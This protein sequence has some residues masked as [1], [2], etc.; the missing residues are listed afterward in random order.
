MGNSQ[1][2]SAA[3]T[4]DLARAIRQYLGRSGPLGGLAG[5][6][7][8]IDVTWRR[9][10]RS[11][12][13]GVPFSP[14]LDYQFALGDIGRFREAE[15]VPAT[16]AG[17]SRTL[18]VTHTVTLPL[19]ISIMDRYSR[20]SSTSWS[21]VLDTQASVEA[22]QTT[23]PDLSLRWNSSPAWVSGLISSVGAQVGA[24]VTKGFTFQPT[25][26]TGVVPQ[27]GIRSEQT[28]KQF[29]INGSVTWAIVG[30]LSTS[31][32]WNRTDR[33]ELRS[34]GLT[35]G[36]Q[37]D[38]SVDLG[39][40]FKVPDGWDIQGESIRT[41]LSYQSTQSRSFFVAGDSRRRVTDNGRWTVTG[42]ADTDVSDTMTFSF[43]VS[44]IMSFDKNYDRRFTQTILSAVLQLQ[45]FAGELR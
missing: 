35:V 17:V 20:A 44:R 41:R 10:L 24:R 6:L 8:P 2:L 32:G 5:M 13:E 16:A 23:F 40:S 3:A 31:A 11:S 45:F 1:G 28:T 39:K 25:A 30:G 4:V 38:I 12:F 14:S 34:G 21:R 26:L 19:G 29:P 18:A 9:D 43:T 33:S 42:S 7:G 37:D 15:G 27:E 36:R 22:R